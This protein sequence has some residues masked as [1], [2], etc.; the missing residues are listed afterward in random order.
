MI[1]VKR[2]QNINYRWLS[3]IQPSALRYD[4]TRWVRAD[5]YLEKSSW[6]ISSRFRGLLIQIYQEELW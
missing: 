2:I 5:F 6:N 3:N 1:K 4:E